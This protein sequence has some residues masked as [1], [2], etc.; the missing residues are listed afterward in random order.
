VFLEPYDLKLRRSAGDVRAIRSDASG[1]YTFEGLAPGSY[2]VLATFEFASV[3]SAL[4]DSAGARVIEVA[5]RME[6]RQD[7]ELYEI[8]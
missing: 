2:R 5:E 1:R 6:A 3:D 7:L 8:R 4:L